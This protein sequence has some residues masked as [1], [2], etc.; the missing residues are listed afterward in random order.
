MPVK[1]IVICGPT[2]IGKTKV[3]MA[4]AKKLNGE[5]VSA[6]SQQVYKGLNIGTAKPSLEDR[7]AVCHHLIDVAEPALQFDAAK[8]VELADKAINGIIER[9]HL[10][11][12]VGG[13]GLYIKALLHG[14]AEAPPRDEKI[15]RELLEIKEKRGISHL[16]KILK[17]SDPDIASRLKP[18]DSARIIR[19]LEVLK[20]TG[21]SIGEFH[22]NHKFKAS[23][24]QALKI[25]LNMDR[26]ELYKRIDARVDKMIKDGLLEEVRGLISKYGADLPAFKAVGYKEIADFCKKIDSPSLDEKVVALVKRNT[27]RYAKR[28]LTWFRADKEIQWFNPAF[29]DKTHVM[30]YEYLREDTIYG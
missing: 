6:D 4:L 20:S 30:A 24:Y 7:A 17:E 12:I 1:I 10:P 25:G 2:C 15:R 27:R 23:R 22:K 19:A 8:F 5:I 26:A 29:L 13:T 3:G 9:G 18:G 14:L 16:Y 28:Q 11:F 21:K